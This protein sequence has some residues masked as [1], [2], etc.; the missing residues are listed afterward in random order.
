MDQNY[1]H[2]KIG[3]LTESF[4]VAVMQHQR[5]LKLLREIKSGD[6]DLDL[7]TM[8]ADGWEVVPVKPEPDDDGGEEV[9]DVAGKVGAGKAG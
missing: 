9:P 5:T 3:R 2:A 4:D 6:V 1:Y 8:T 7:V